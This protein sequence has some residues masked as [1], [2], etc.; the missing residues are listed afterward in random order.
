[1][2]ADMG[3]WGIGDL[4]YSPLQTL[5]DDMTA[6]VAVYTTEGFVLGSDGRGSWN[7]TP[8]TTGTLAI[9]PTD[10]AQKIFSV[11]TPTCKLAYAVAGFVYNDTGTFSMLR[12][13]ESQSMASLRAGLICYDYVNDF[14]KKLQRRITKA[15]QDGEVE[16]FHRRDGV[17]DE[18][19]YTVCRI[20][21]AGYMDDQPCFKCARIRL[22]R[23]G[24]RLV[25]EVESVN[26]VNGN[27]VARGGAIAPQLAVRGDARF[28]AYSIGLNTPP[29]D[30]ATAFTYARAYI[31][32]CSD[33]QAGSVDPICNIIGGRVQIAKITPAN[34]FEWFSG[35][36]PAMP[37]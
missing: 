35:F 4:F 2:Q 5:F 7:G 29:T 25:H 6:I 34:G 32:C 17:S 10:D 12:E 27:S 21:F 1:M 16:P 19:S 26:I 15:I 13:C 28:S 18:E 33:P 14:G 36:E 3:D 11:S 8:L 22:S 31:E 30:L 23:D 9:S 37:A 24:G 20:T